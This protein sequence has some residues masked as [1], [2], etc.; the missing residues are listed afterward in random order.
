MWMAGLK[1]GLMASFAC[2]IFQDYAAAKAARAGPWSNGQTEGQNSKLKL[3]RRQ[4]YGR[5][6]LVLPAHLV[7]AVLAPNRNVP[8]AQS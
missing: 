1:S 6:G 4:M 3:V 5:A 8:F 2:G 7:S